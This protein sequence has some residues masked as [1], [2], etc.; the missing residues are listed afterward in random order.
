MTMRIRTGDPTKPAYAVPMKK[1]DFAGDAWDFLSGQGVGTPDDAKA[2]AMV[3]ESFFEA[4]C[5]YEQER[6]AT[7]WRCLIKRNI[8]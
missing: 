1:P 4:G 6:A 5:E 3:L 2:L 7:E 8:A